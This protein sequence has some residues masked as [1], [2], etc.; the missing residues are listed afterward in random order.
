MCPSIEI[1]LCERGGVGQGRGSNGGVV[2]VI[3][4]VCR[5]SL[6]S[7]LL[8]SCCVVVYRDEELSRRLSYQ[9]ISHR[10]AVP[11]VAWTYVDESPSVLC[12]LA[13]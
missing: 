9:F 1:V 4:E 2:M 7:S 5:G 6:W 3:R 12:I 8:L 13:Q 10:K 11:Y